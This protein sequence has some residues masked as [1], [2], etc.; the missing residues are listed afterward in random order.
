M[1]QLGARQAA[2][3]RNVLFLFAVLIVAPKWAQGSD[4]SFDGGSGCGDPPIFSEVFNLPAVNASGGMCKAFGNGTGV[5]ITSFKFTAP[6]PNASPT[7]PFLCS[8]A[9]FFLSCDFLVTDTSG[10]V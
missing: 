8:P 10:G 9:P 2:C 1:L 7:D 6:L 3:V 4:M 5:N